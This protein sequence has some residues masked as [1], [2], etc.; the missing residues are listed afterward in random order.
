M[1]GAKINKKSTSLIIIY[2]SAASFGR[3]AI[4]GTNENRIVQHK[5]KWRF[6]FAIFALLEPARNAR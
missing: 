3:N 6:I 1:I 2:S 5:R 4:S